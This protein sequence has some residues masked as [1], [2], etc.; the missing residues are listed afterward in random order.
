MFGEED[1]KTFERFRDSFDR[2]IWQVS[3]C[4]DNVLHG[5]FFESTNNPVQN[6][7]AT[8]L[9]STYYLANKI[10]EQM[11]NKF[12]DTIGGLKLDTQF[13]MSNWPVLR[14]I[15]VN[16]FWNFE[17]VLHFTTCSGITFQIST[18]PNK[19]RWNFIR[20]DPWWRTRN[21]RKCECANR[22]VE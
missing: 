19:L 12:L 9:Q 20:W 5:F 15:S 21:C 17:T 16:A 14:P 8:K 1:W 3:T 4:L 10:I 2:K 7:L 11:R 13:S 22:S 18:S 6:D